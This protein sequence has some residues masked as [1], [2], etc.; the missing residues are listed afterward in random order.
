MSD[1]KF[2]LVFFVLI[3][4]KILIAQTDQIRKDIVDM[5][6]VLSRTGIPTIVTLHP[7]NEGYDVNVFFM[8]SITNYQ[9]VMGA[10]IG[11][12]GECTRRSSYKTNYCYI[13]SSNL[14]TERIKTYYLR[15]AQ[16]YGLEGDIERTW[17]IFVNNKSYCISPYE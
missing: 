8:G 14:K 15:K 6:M 17:S 1:F 5:S 7:T 3:L 11:A 10:V 12:V 4:A 13:V 9:G 16:K 2:L